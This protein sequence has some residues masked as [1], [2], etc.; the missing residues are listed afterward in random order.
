MKKFLNVISIV[1]VTLLSIFLAQT[2]NIVR[3]VGFV[4]EEITFETCITIYIT[5][6]EYIR[7]ILIDS[8]NAY[9]NKNKSVIRCVFYKK[10]EVEDI[11]YNPMLKING[12]NHIE[13]IDVVVS[14]KGK[15][16]N[17]KDCLI[18]SNFPDWVDIQ[19]GNKDS[20]SKVVG[21]KCIINCNNILNNSYERVNFSRKNTIQIVKTIS[22]DGLKDE[23]KFKCNK[24][25]SP[26]I[27]FENNILNI[28]NKQ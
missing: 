20:A 4:P 10:G 22:E 6:L 9:I 14:I 8:I 16:K 18:E 3:Y 17:F 7:D 26:F 25:T 1:L 23:I 11:N 28:K 15:K 12:G 21:R 5:I 2:F 24:S 19:K 13:Q 27:T